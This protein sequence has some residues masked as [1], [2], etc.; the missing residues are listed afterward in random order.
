MGKYKYPEAFKRMKGTAKDHPCMKSKTVITS[1][2][3][4][5]C[6]N[7]KFHHED[8]SH[9][10]TDGGEVTHIRGWI[11]GGSELGFYSEWGEHGLC[12]CHENENSK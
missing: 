9:P 8:H 11:C 7:C 12:E 1:L 3:K 5:C 4:C 10:L 6:C 2:E